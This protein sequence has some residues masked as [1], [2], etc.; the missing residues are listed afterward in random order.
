MVFQNISNEYVKNTL[1][2]PI[3]NISII[4]SLHAWT[5]YFNLHNLIELN[6]FYQTTSSSLEAKKNYY[7]LEMTFQTF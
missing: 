7:R 3:R 2:I 1:K 4:R 5:I 6:N